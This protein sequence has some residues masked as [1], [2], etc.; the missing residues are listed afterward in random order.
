MLNDFKYY[1]YNAYEIVRD[2]KQ[3]ESLRA[4]KKSIED[5]V[6]SYED[7]RDKL[8]CEIERLKEN[9]EYSKQSVKIISELYHAGF[10]FEE[11]RQ[12]KNTVGEISEAYNISWYEA[13]KKF[14]QDIESQYDSKLGFETKINDLKTEKKKLESEVPGYK[15][16]LQSQV[17]ALGVLQ[18]LYRYGVTDDDIINMSDVVM[19][20]LNG[21]ITFKLNQQTENIVDEN[22]FIRKPYYWRSF[23]NEIKNLGDIN[24]QI[25]NQSS[26][27]E[28]IKKEVDNLNSQRQKLNEQTLLSGQ[29]LNSINAQF[30]YFMESIKKIML[31]IKETNKM[32]IIYQPLFLINVTI[33]GDPKDDNNKNIKDKSL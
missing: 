4:E 29:L 11:L 32:F 27:L 7:K 23:I 13:G 15:E 5:I 21:N 14:I 20:Y 18:Y 6:K 31:S 22:K 17:N 1:G 28:E 26:Y 3:L 2:Y 9:E 16:R 25:A 30:P 19:A 12:L 8:F 24:S 33:R 10:E